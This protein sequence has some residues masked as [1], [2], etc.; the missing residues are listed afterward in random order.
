MAKQPTGLGK[1]LGA[2]IP[3]ANSQAPGSVTRISTP[4]DSE[5]FSSVS[6]SEIEANPYQPRDG[7]DQERLD[8]LAQSI[9]THGLIQPITVRY[10]S[11]GR[12]QLISGE[13]RFRAAQM[14]GLT[15][16]PAYIRQANDQAMLEMAI[17]ENLQREDLNAIEISLSFQRL[18]EECNL[19]QEALADQ[20]GKNR[21]TVTNYLRLLKL[22]PEIQLA[23]SRGAITMGHARA[24]LSV[25]NKERQLAITE[26]ILKQGLSVRHI[27]TLVQK[28]KMPKTSSSRTTDVDT[29]TELPETYF[30]L[31]DKIGQ[32]FNN[33]IRI[34]RNPRGSGTITIHV[35]N[36]KQ[37]D[38]FLRALEFLKK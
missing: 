32:Y 27:E 1:G 21:S 16:L 13:R 28:E 4:S 35:S 7:F 9:R 20:I 22:P 19:T 10:V 12:Y 17:I 5:D 38:H 2:L 24:L 25:D 11:H 23:L 26:Q 14:I 34:K 3:G 30:L 36:D 33:E 6:L 37:V 29:S 8:D 18:I 31:I 15:H